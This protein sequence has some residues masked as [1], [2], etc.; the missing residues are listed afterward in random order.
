MDIYIKKTFLI[1]SL[2]KTVFFQFFRFSIHKT[3]DSKYSMDIYKSVKI[4]IGTVMK[5][6]KKL[7]FVPDHLKTE[8]TCKHAA[9][10]LPFLTRYISD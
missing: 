2:L 4:S 10:K 8:K 9:R 3:V 6:P 1:F 5:N 7:K